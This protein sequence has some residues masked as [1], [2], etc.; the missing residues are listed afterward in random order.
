MIIKTTSS[1]EKI[2]LDDK[3]KKI[4]EFTNIIA[5][6]GER[7]SYQIV[8][9]ADK[10]INEFENCI[11]NLESDLKDY[12]QIRKV[13]NVPCE[14]PVYRTRHDDNY[15]R[16]NPGL[17]PDLLL[18]MTYVSKDKPYGFVKA[19]PNTLRSLWIDL[20]IPNNC[21]P[22]VHEIKI[23]FTSELCTKESIFNIEILDVSLPKQELIYTEWFHQDALANYYNVPVF[24]KKHFNIIR[25]YVR[26][27]HKN[28][29][30]MILVPV[31][32]PPLDTEVG[33]E[34][35]TTQLVEITKNG[36]EYSFN[37]D[38]LDKFLDLLKEEGI[39]YYEISH[40]FT[41]WG[42]Y[43]APKIIAKVNG[44][45]K[46]IF[47]WET[48]SCSNEYIS[49]L[50][51]FIKSFIHHMKSRGEDKKCYYHIS[52]EPSKEHLES[53]MNCK[54]KISD[55]LKDYTIMDALSNFEFYQMGIVNTPIPAS[56]HIEPFL[57]A[58]VKN[59][60]TYYC[61][62]QCIGTSNRLIS[63]P[64]YRNRSIGIQMYKYDIKGFLQWGYNF[65]NNRFSH[66]EIEPYIE[67]SGEYWVPAGD[68]FLCISRQ[69]WRSS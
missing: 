40:F 39:E 6:K 3:L 23:S 54:S 57:E 69:K 37:Y 11:I 28:G 12:I 7:I 58:G 64:S 27:A 4:K 34:R 14:Y 46:K 17:Y 36:E 52:D 22:G 60:W 32:T 35:L 19:I 59:L 45:K 16:T 5:L 8:F 25:N 21:T 38:L 49:F 18:P 26:I 56:D 65:Y 13:K 55:L 15:L 31:F 51:Q 67:S 47:G 62:G 68:A 43:H 2:F 24:S 48:D 44:R 29:I 53:Y 61:C 50:R 30:N 33:G 10:S 42:A 20:I 66:D 63:M 9:T 1:Q 41:Q